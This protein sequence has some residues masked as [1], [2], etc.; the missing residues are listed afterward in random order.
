MLILPWRGGN[1]V[2]FE[3]QTNKHEV[4]NPKPETNGLKALNIKLKTFLIF[5]ILDLDIVS[6]FDIRILCLKYNSYIYNYGQR[7]PNR[8]STQYWNY[9]SY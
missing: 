7:L 5:P 1:K 6:N 4:R 9:R 8:K 2:K 3:A